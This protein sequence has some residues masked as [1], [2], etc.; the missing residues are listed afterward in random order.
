MTSEPRLVKADALQEDP[1]PTAGMTRRHAIAA[2]GLTSGTVTTAPGV[3]SGWHHHGTH[4]TSIYVLR[5]TLRMESAGGTFD[6]HEG[7]FI[8]MPAGAV[9][10]ESN[11]GTE[12]NRAVFSRAGSGAVTVNV[13]APPTG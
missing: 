1:N 6:A 10:R 7:D 12:P 8:H 9:H 5:G 13:E 2:N 11:P 3:I 4:E